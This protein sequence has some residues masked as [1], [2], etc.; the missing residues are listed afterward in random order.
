MKGHAVLHHPTSGRSWD[1]TCSRDSWAIGIESGGRSHDAGH[2]I[3]WAN[4]GSASTVL[5]PDTSIPN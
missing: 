1:V 3:E 4:T 2:A 5:R